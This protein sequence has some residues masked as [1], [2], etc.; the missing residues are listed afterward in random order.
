MTNALLTS[1]RVAYQ[2]ADPEGAALVAVAESHHGR[3]P[4]LDRLVRH[5][6][7]DGAPLRQQ[8]QVRGRLQP[9]ASRCVASRCVA[10]RGVL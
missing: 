7:L 6:R 4:Y 8:A 1:H 3:D 2:D 9:G 5:L 10:L